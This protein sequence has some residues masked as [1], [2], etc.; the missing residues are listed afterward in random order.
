MMHGLRGL[1][2]DSTLAERPWLFVPKKLKTR[3][4]VEKASQEERDE[5]NAEVQGGAGEG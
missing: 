5:Q 3:L 4:A 1:G 2:L